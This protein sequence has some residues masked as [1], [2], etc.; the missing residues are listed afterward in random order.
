MASMSPVMTKVSGLPSFRVYL[1]VVSNVLGKQFSN[2]QRSFSSL[3]FGLVSVM[4]AS[5]AFEVKCRL[6]GAGRRDLYA[7]GPSA[8]EASESKG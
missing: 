7:E 4:T 1:T 8:T 2:I 5:T 3:I 6:S